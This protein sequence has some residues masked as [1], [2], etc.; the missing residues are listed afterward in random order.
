MR[1]VVCQDRMNYNIKEKNNGSDCDNLCWFT[2]LYIFYDDR[3]DAIKGSNNELEKE[4]KRQQSLADDVQHQLDLLNSSQNTLKLQGK[5]QKEINDLKQIE[6]KKLIDIQELELESQKQRLQSLID[7]REGGGKG[8]ESFIRVAGG[9][10]TKFSQIVEG[11]LGKFGID[12]DLGKR[13]AVLTDNVLEKIFGTKEDIEE[14]EEKVESLEKALAA[15]ANTRDGIIL[16]ERGGAAKEIVDSVIQALTPEQ[17][18][19]LEQAQQLQDQLT[20]IAKQGQD[21]REEDTKASAENHLEIEEAI[22]EAKR[23]ILAATFDNTRTAFRLL[24]ALDRKSRLL[25]AVSLLGESASGIAKIVINTQAANAAVA[26]KYALIPAPAGPLLIAAEKLQ[27]K[28]S[29]GVGIAANILATKN[30]LARLKAGGS[31]GGGGV[32]TGGGGS[33]APQFNLVRGTES[34][35]ILEGIQLQLD[36]TPIKTFVVDRDMTTQQEL[37]RNIEATNSI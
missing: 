24:G 30:A 7:I 25:Q 8:L 6:I 16:S 35:Q 3:N 1:G 17:I 5:T 11:V 29:A 12:I 21:Q 20:D 23:G 27:N 13:T 22:A 32:E 33:R 31:V 4:I 2:D 18:G 15:L 19:I 10:L 28:I 9:I 34:N 37:T 26:F 14:Q 36:R